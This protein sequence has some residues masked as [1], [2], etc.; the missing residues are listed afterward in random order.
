MPV[1][2]GNIREKSFKD[3]WF[4]SKIFR[5]L[6]DFDK[7]KGKCGVCEYNDVCGGCRARAY[8]VNT[9]QMDFC[10]ALHEPEELRG[11]YLEEDPWCNYQP[12]NLF[13]KKE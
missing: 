1:S 2:L 11:D 5:S 7:L 4:N 13:S 8:G 10:G 9:E 6:R 12:K 3:I